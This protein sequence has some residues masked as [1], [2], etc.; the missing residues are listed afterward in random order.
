MAKR[1]V[2]KEFN[3]FIGEYTIKILSGYRV[4]IPGQF[5]KLLGKEFIMTKGYEGAIIMLDIPRWNQLLEPLKNV[6]FWNSDLRDTLRFLVASAFR[7][8]FDKY[9]RVIIPKILREFIKVNGKSDLI[10][11]GVYNWIELWLSDTWDSYRRN[12]E[13]KAGSLANKIRDLI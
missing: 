4:V 1:S 10:V 9:G 6:S 3:Y 13:D 11:I 5:R 8:E 12:I 2:N 7:V